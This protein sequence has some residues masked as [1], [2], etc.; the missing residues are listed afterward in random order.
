M[1]IQIGQEYFMQQLG[2]SV[3]VF[4]RRAEM[5]K[6]RPYQV[7]KLQETLSDAQMLK[8]HSDKRRKLRKLLVRLHQYE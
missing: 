2:L 6:S 8:T 1:T 4:R 7:M 5:A 3:F